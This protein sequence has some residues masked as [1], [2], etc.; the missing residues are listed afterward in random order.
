MEQVNRRDFVALLGS[1]ATM[2]PLKSRGQTSS[3]PI[4]NPSEAAAHFY[5]EYMG[6]GVVLKPLWERW[7]TVRLQRVLDA[8]YGPNNAILK[9]KEGDPFL[10]WKNWEGTWRTKLKAEQLDA[11]ADR[12]QVLVTL[13]TD[14]KGQPLARLVHLVRSGG[15]WRID[16]VTDPP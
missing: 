6:M 9:V 12:A 3:A 11:S 8:F 5:R 1:V 10:P 7:L 15:A 4:E 13:A 14:E 2:W 16:D